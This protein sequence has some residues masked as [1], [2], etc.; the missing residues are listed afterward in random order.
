[1][2]AVLTYERKSIA[3]I[4]GSEGEANANLKL[5]DSLLDLSGE[6]TTL[7]DKD[8]H[9][10]SEKM[11]SILSELKEKGVDLLKSDSKQITKEQLIELKSVIGSHI[12]KSRTKVQQIFMKMQNT[13][14]NMM[15]VNDSAKR[16]LSEFIQLIRTITKNMR[17]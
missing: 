13:I 1:M 10:L 16:F 15:S 3:S 14:Q 6:L 12:D 9:E 4:L 2:R 17:P 5:I 7:G 8:K 11:T